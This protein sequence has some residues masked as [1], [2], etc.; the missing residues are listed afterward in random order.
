MRPKD[1]FEIFKRDN[2]TCQYCGSSAPSVVLHIDHISPRSKGGEDSFLN[3]VTSCWECNIG[4]GNRVLS[5]SAVV[6]KQVA[7]IEVEKARHNQAK[8]QLE[9]LLQW[10]RETQELASKS[11]ACVEDILGLKLSKSDTAIVTAWGRKY[12]FRELASAVGTSAE[13]YILKGK[14]PELAFEKVGAI[15][16][17]R[18]KYRDQ[19]EMIRMY[20]IRS[21]LSSRCYL[22]ESKSSQVLF[23]LK[24]AFDRGA[25]LEDLEFLALSASN[26]RE[27]SVVLDK[28]PLEE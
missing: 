27:F 23:K 9:M 4:K 12:G 14:P 6:N 28:M 1:R 17:L 24:A 11:I 18:S 20:K 16:Y 21:L 22:S 7:Q 19:P 10:Q 26:Y 8:E 2:F 3:L 15:L 25:S 13:T 5:E